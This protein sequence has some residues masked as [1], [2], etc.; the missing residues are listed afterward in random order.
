MMII[1]HKKAL[2][3]VSGISNTDLSLTMFTVLEIIKSH[4]LQ[5]S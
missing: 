4:L 1:V 2:Y 3:S 5:N